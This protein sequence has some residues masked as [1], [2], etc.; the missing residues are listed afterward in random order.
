MLYSSQESCGT[1]LGLN[2]LKNV[3]WFPL[4][5]MGVILKGVMYVHKNQI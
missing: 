1:C 4:G 5:E 2:G 3:I